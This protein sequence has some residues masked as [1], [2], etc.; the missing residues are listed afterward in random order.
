MLK[1]TREEI[2]QASWDVRL[3]LTP[4]E[5]DGLEKRAKEMLKQAVFLQDSLLDV[6]TATSL[7]L[8]KENTVREDAFAPS[9]SQE[10]AL[11]NAPE[12]DPPYMQVPKIVE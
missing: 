8:V 5:M 4:E 6:V 3:E 10:A 7:P 9:L 11:S 1:I 12:V 2:M